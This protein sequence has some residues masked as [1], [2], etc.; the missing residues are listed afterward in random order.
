MVK[1]TRVARTCVRCPFCDTP[2]SMLIVRTTKSPRAACPWQAW[3]AAITRAIGK[4][5]YAEIEE[6][7]EPFEG[8]A[9]FS[10]SPD[11]DAFAFPTEEEAT[12][13]LKDVLMS[14]KLRVAALGPY[15]WGVDGNYQVTPATGF[16]PEYMDAIFGEFQLAYPGVEMERVWYETSG[17][18][19]DAIVNEECHLSEPY[20][21][22]PSFYNGVP[23]SQAF[24]MSCTTMGYESRF[25]TKMDDPEPSD[26]DGLSEGAIIAIVVSRWMG[27][28]SPASSCACISSVVAFAFLVMIVCLVHHERRGRPMFAPL[29]GPS[30]QTIGQVSTDVDPAL[31]L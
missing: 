20:W 30:K 17:E 3:D 27:M 8:I 4:G 22:Q 15:N 5:K 19:M 28:P 23:R 12:G 10:C 7:H 13:M 14:G 16:W 24:K 25:F 26:D 1:S 18:T 9:S 2:R 21:V 29:L 11:D 6:K 31:K